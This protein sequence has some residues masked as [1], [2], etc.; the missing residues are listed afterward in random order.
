[1]KQSYASP[2][3]RKKVWTPSADDMPLPSSHSTPSAE[4]SRTRVLGNLQAIDVQLLAVG[5]VLTLDRTSCSRVDA[6]AADDRYLG[7]R[8]SRALAMGMHR[9]S[10][11]SGDK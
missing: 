10:G 9:A 6:R 1:M 11:E 7:L 4:V 8:W 3:T 2:A 5:E